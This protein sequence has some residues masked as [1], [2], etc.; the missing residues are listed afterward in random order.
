MKSGMKKTAINT[1]LW[2]TL[3][4][5]MGVSLS[6]CSSE[7]EEAGAKSGEVLAIDRVDDAAALA[8]TNAPKAENMDFPETAPMPAADVA[9]DAAATATASTEGDAA[10]ADTSATTATDSA[11]TEVAVADS[12]DMPA[13][14]ATTTSE[15]EP[16]TN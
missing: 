8:R 14:D 10:V 9:A 7:K 12:A 3:V 13:A 5:T 2:T 11:G 4:L 16:A 1:A 15:A 6:A